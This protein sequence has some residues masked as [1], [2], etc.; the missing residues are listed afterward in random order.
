MMMNLCV[1]YVKVSESAFKMMNIC[2]VA[3]KI[4]VEGLANL[5]AES[6][7]KKTRVTSVKKTKKKNFC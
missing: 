6:S 5:E 3:F 1:L 7:F 2:R 4:F